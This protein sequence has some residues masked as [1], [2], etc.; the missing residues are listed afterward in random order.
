MHIVDDTT[1]NINDSLTMVA[2]ATD[3][4][5]VISY[6]WAVDGISFS[7]TTDSG[8]IMAAWHN[9][10]R[11]V[12]RVAAIDDDGVVC[13]PDSCIV[14]VSLDPPVFTPVA[15]TTVSRADSLTVSVTAADAN[16]GGRIEKYYWD[17]GAN[18][19]DDSTDIPSSSFAYPSGGYVHVVW[20]ARD[21]DRAFSRDTFVVLFNNAPSWV[22]LKS[23]RNA[24]T[25]Q[26]EAFNHVSMN[27]T[28][29]FSFSGSDPDGPGDSLTYTFEIGK[30]VD[31]LSLIYRGRKDTCTWASLDT[32]ATY[33]W[34]LAAHDFFGDSAIAMGKFFTRAAPPL[35]MRLI[36]ARGVTFEMGSTT[37]RDNEEPV[38]PV[39]FTHDF[40]MDTTEV[41]QT[42]YRLRMGVN[43]SYFHGVDNPVEFVS[44]FDAA[45]YCNARSHRDGK[46]TV[47]SYS[48][49][50][51]IPGLG[52]ILNDLAIDMK[53]D[54]YRL[55]TESE[56]EFACR[57]GTTTDR[58][59]G[60][61]D[62]GLYAWYSPNCGATTHPVAKKQPNQFKLYDMNGNVWEWC[63][64]WFVA[65][66]GGLHTD[67]KGPP[68]G[69][70][71]VLRGGG[72]YDEAS[73][74]RSAYRNP[75]YPAY[76]S[77][78]VGFRVVLVIR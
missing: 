64:D 36:K 10:G 60:N 6:I 27:G 2:K 72:W 22:A 15:D 34:R 16:A 28:A 31:A 43:P 70:D 39:I 61:A 12:L 52:C 67:P 32:S 73:Y 51:G 41:T 55:P 77:D 14:N 24:D 49:I 74:V 59:W 76:R 19:W 58:Y 45:L 7:D 20:A 29:G 42:E 25:V 75:C 3:N 50:S 46:D 26:W 54:G 37:G 48:S 69:T 1:V 9:A 65:Y 21:D 23:P 62:I 68:E 40:W 30:V 66:K 44:W 63:N 11:H 17:I 13:A 8:A 56:W 33:I 38:H 71:R 53:K 4:G 78:S 47:Y 18:G 57:A 5:Q 35:G